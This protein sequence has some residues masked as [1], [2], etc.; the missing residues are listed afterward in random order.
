MSI[1]ITEFAN[2]S[3]SVSPVGVASGNF[4]ILG[5]LTRDTDDASYPIQVSERARSYANL[6][7]VAADWNDGSEV[8]AAASAFYGQTPTPTDFTVLMQYTTAQ[9]ASILG[10]NA[11]TVAVIKQATAETLTIDIDGTPFPMTG[12]DFSSAVDEDDVADILNVY[13][14]FSAVAVAAWDG[15][16][17][18]ITTVSTGIGSLIT[19]ATGSAAELL[20]LESHEVVISNGINPESEVEALSE[21]LAANKPFVG[22]VTH[23]DM[24]DVS[25]ADADGN[26]LISSVVDIATF[27]TGAKKIFCNTSN[28]L[29]TL[30]ATTSDI[31]SVLLG[32]SGYVLN[33][34][35]R[36]IKTY[37]SASVFGRAASVNFSGIDTTITLNLKQMPTITAE[38]LTKAEYDNLVAK[39]CSAVV[40]IGSSINAYTSSRMSNGSW[41]DTTHGLLWLENR[42]EVDMFNLLYQSATKI[43]YTQAGINTAAATLERSLKAAVRNGLAGP[44]YLPDGTF[45]PEGYRINVVALGD[46]SSADKSNRLYAGLSF[47]MV[48]TGA[49]HEV[50]VTGNFAE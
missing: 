36:N 21:A 42:A 22:L 49:L 9:S 46:V 24:R 40:R 11:E 34:F 6:A 17:Y 27:C 43:P 12:L 30:T 2:V 37:P 31:A 13:A 33:T 10:G 25:V 48:G 4:G 29:T 18:T 19:A 45:L 26:A 44:G 38:D 8:L 16:R 35:S 1:E 39:N 15:Y 50:I 28:D 7:G 5:F 3:I 20:A 23:R 41:L 32:F 47:D 14:G